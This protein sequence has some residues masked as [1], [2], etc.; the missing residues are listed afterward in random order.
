MIRQHSAPVLISQSGELVKLAYVEAGPWL[1]HLTLTSLYG[2]YPILQPYSCSVPAHRRICRIS[3]MALTC[4]L[5][6]LSISPANDTSHAPACLANTA[7]LPASLWSL[8]ALH[9]ATSSGPGGRGRKL[10]AQARIVAHGERAGRDE[11]A[12]LQS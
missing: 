6:S 5:G 7:G 9:D 1:M 10:C 2:R 8:G 3:Y 12:R 11:E 4:R